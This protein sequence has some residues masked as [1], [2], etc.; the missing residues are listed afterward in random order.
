M[1]E[2][3]TSKTAVLQD[4]IE[5]MTELKYSLINRNGGFAQITKS[6][7]HAWLKNPQKAVENDQDLKE[8]LDKQTHGRGYCYSDYKPSASK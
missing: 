3:L 6:Q 5:E 2:R 1:N 7:Y 4:L 8:N